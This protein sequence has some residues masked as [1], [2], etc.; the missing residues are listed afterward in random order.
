[1]KRI[2]FLFIV[3]FLVATVFPTSSHAEELSRPITAWPLLYHKVEKDRAETDALFS[4]Y[5]YRRK[6][7]WSKY[8]FGYVLFSTEGDPAKEFRK[9]RV[10]WPLSTYE[11]K[12]P[13]TWFHLFPLYWYKSAPGYHHNVLFPVYWDI[14]GRGYSAFHVWPFFGI[15]RRGES[16]AEYSTL[17]PF[18][19]YGRDTRT[20]EVDVNAPWPLINYHRE[21]DHL[22]HRVLPLYWY[23]ET[24]SSSSGFVTLYFWKTTPDFSSRGIFP[25]WYS[26]RGTTE[27]TDLVFPLY[28]NRET[29]ESRLRFITPFAVSRKTPES[30]ASLIV[31][32]YFNYESSETRARMITPLYFTRRSGESSFTMFLPVY[33]D[34]ETRDSG[35]RLG[36]PVYGRYRSGPFTFSTFFPLYYHSEDTG[37]RSE[38]TYYFPLYGMYRRGNAVSRHFVLFPLYSQ[39]RDEELQLR[40]WDVLWPLFHYETSPTT[41]SVHLLPLYWHSSTPERSFTVGFPLYW[42]F[43]SGEDSF[44][45]IAPFYA[46]NRKGDWYRQR[47]FLGPLYMDTVDTRAGLSKQEALFWLFSRKAQGDEK[48]TWFIPLYYHHSDADSLLTLWLLPPYVHVK[49][50]GKEWLH[51]WPLFGKVRSGTYTEYS[52]L[53]PLIRFGSDP[54]NDRSMAHVLLFYRARQGQTSDTVFVPLWY[55]HGGPT[56]TIDTSLFLHWYERDESL[57]R[58]RL[59]FFWLIPGTDI[60]LFRYH[61]QGDVLKHGLFPL[62]TYFFDES[63]DAL[64][65]TF[66]RPLFTYERRGEYLFR[67]GLLMSYERKDAD[68]SEFR[69]LWRFIHRARTKTSSMFEFNPFYYYESEEGKGSYWAVLGGLF[70]L[71]TTPEMK[72]RYRVF[73]IF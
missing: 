25:L 58:T 41:L 57:D 66:L 68:T 42:S 38:F 31:P 73:W 33:F 40:A 70:G 15:N 35:L 4:L 22:T 39:L 37:L 65:W 34:Y 18:F 71:E 6:D 3:F 24:G 36:L 14:E 19:R 29:P 23:D 8:S 51:L 50:P 62:Y 9:T 26:A 1:M 52:T 11:R 53:W 13:S 72:K 49:D 69:F 59:N 67:G 28:F 44:R 46:V 61:R 16:F 47:F 60:S 56:A 30:S 10:I 54:V 45:L 7:T 12:G 64:K 2:V 32:L 17:W 55:H 43:S 48:R 63:E 21:G 27:K 5:H 20:G